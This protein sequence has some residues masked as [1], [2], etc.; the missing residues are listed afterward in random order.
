MLAHH[1]TDAT[2]DKLKPYYDN[3]I[4]TNVG[5][6]RQCSITPAPTM[7]THNTALRTMIAGG[8]MLVWCLNAGVSRIQ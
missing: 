3:A 8:L 5:N 2:I 6:L 4:R 1:F 7:D